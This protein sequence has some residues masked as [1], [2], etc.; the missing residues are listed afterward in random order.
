MQKKTYFIIWIAFYKS[1]KIQVKYDENKNG[2]IHKKN[3]ENYVEIDYNQMWN[4]VIQF[5]DIT[6]KMLRL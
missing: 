4:F 1:N 5:S 3:A 6:I 2:N